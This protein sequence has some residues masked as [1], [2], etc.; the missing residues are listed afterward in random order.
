MTNRR[1]RESTV[2]AWSLGVALVMTL[3][4]L[5]GYRAEPTRTA[6]PNGY[7]SNFFD[8]QARALMHFRLAV[9]AGSLSIEGFVVNGKEYL[10]FGPLPAV[11]RIPV[12]LVAPGLEG[13]LSAPMMLVAWFIGAAATAGLVWRV[14]TL[15]RGAVE[16]D[17]R[18]AWSY[19]ALLTASTAGPPLLLAAMPWVYN[20][21]MMW[22]WASAMAV[23]F[24]IIGIL[25]KPTRQRVLLLAVAATLAAFSRVTVAWPTGLAAI[26]VAAALRTRPRFVTSRRWAVPVL[27]AG[28]IP[29]LGAV[30]LNWVRFGHPFLLPF[31]HQRWTEVSARRR[32]ILAEGGVEGFRFLP[33][34]LVAYFRPDG[35]RWS[36]IF[37][38]VGAPGVPAEI[39]ANLEMRY[40]TPSLWWV[41]PVHLV[42]GI[43]GVRLLWRK[44]RE[45]AGRSMLIPVACAALIPVAVLLVG[46]VA[47]RYLV[48]FLPI[49]VLL[50]ALGLAHMAEVDR[51]F[52][53][54]RCAAIVASAVMGCSVNL[55]NAS[56]T[57][58]YAEGAGR[59]ATL[60]R[61][62]LSFAD[63]MGVN[64]SDRIR[65]GPLIPESSSPDTYFI[66]GDCRAALVG[67]GDLYEPW[68]AFVREPI[69]LTVH[70]TG[71][72]S[73]PER[74]PLAVVPAT[75]LSV[76][77]VADGQGR[78]R[79]EA[80]G[81]SSGFPIGPWYSQSTSTDLTVT[82]ALSVNGQT[83][84]VLAPGSLVTTLP[85][86]S[87]S[88]LDLRS[89]M[90]IPLPV[91]ATASWF[92]VVEEP[93]AGNDLCRRLEGKSVS[94]AAGGATP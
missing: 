14:R 70:V 49:G 43:S 92:S 44:R 72:P 40:P 57:E 3:L 53:R 81:A 80:V 18:E 87:R 41:M 6:L 39:G 29:L 27:L 86:L 61:A 82:L 63:L 84:D 76:D 9:P 89:H 77:L 78:F 13:R 11:L 17:R 83:T 5:W 74:H 8:I 7:F 85:A 71:S 46:Y 90:L 62:Q 31:D 26:A 1:S 67:T 48:E 4:I 60:V 88:G 47:P 94:R 79:L 23:L 54:G 35:I 64:V 93:R 50:A 20:E 56:M 24:A 59:L 28:V 10:Y 16:L 25:T 30:L 22:S 45:S 68:V 32:Q 58:R 2:T 51:G 42:T 15:F 38:F 34:T 37:P 52:S 69:K 65:S 21:A 19:G 33:S 55:A 12:L 75:N 66:V 91:S 73:R 36:P